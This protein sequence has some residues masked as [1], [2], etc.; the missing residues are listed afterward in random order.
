MNEIVFLAF[1]RFSV[2]FGKFFTQNLNFFNSYYGFWCIFALY[3]IIVT[4]KD[5]YFGIKIDY[6][7]F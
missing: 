2:I 1:L 6:P 7:E 5:L 3:Y 4:D